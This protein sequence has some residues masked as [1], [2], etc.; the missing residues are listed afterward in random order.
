MKRLIHLHVLALLL[1]VAPL[2]ATAADPPAPLLTLDEAVEIATRGNHLIGAADADVAAAE[3]TVQESRSG[4]QPRLDLLETFS[5]TTNPVFVFGNKLNQ[6][7]FTPSD[8]DFDTLN[9]PD[10]I[11]NVNTMLRVRYAIYSGGK[12]SG[13]VEA[14]GYAREAAEAGRERTR[15]EVVR[16]VVETYTGA[17]LASAHL[18]VAREALGTA[19]ANVE[20]ISDLRE[21]GL[22]VES[23]LLQARVR[24]SEVEEMVIRAE[25][26]VEVARA[27]VNLTLGRDLDTPFALSDRIDPVQD[28][29]LPLEALIEEAR[30]AR[31]DLRA[32]GRQVQAAEQSVRVSRAGRRPEVGIDGMVEANAPELFDSYATNWSVFIGARIPIYDGKEAKGRVRRAEAEALKARQMHDLMRES[33]SLETRQAFH[34]LRASRKSLEHAVSAVDL[35]RE[36]LRMVQ[37]RYREGLAN[38]VELLDAETSLT[39][40]RTREVG[41]RREMMLNH[42]QLELATGRL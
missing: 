36:S 37:D 2:A 12:V 22:V 26:A 28:P 27:A 23:D 30:A 41:T 25:S 20:M 31:P 33:V 4:R 6:G 42:A 39:R 5:R 19:S 34:D 10:A 21:G 18:E 38:L 35:A 15:Q 14:S 40:A 11:N 3:A 17:V 16:Q 8:L 1:A 32:A 13:A 29:D 9:N 7:T 24:E